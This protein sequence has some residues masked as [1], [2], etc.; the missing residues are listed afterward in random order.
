MLQIRNTDLLILAG[1]QAR[2]MGGKDKGLVPLAGRAMIEHVLERVS[3]AP[4]LSSQVWISANRN[5]DAYARYGSVLT[6]S[7]DAFIG[8]LAGML[9]GLKACHS[10]RLLV[11]PCDAPLVHP[12]LPRQLLAPDT[13][14]VVASDAQRWQPV[15][16][17]LHRDL[18]D[19]LSAQLSAGERK[20]DRW[21][22]RHP[23]TVVHID[24][25]DCFSNINSAAEL[26]ALTP[27]IGVTQ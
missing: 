19:D 16:C 9:Q 14:I 20:I 25:I 27:K 22:A 26:T 6:D 23:H 8:P 24:H 10:E 12:D 4:G 1:G 13:P 3:G 2:R 11:L 7:S 17:C 21:F 5:L 15:F 18:I